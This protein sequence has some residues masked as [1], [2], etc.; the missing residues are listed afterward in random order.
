MTPRDF[1]YWLQGHFEMNDPKCF[2]TKQVAMVKA[3]LD[4]VFE[5]VTETQPVNTPQT[6][7]ATKSFLEG[8]GDKNLVPFPYLE[9]PT[10]KALFDY[11]HKK[12]VC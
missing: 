5:N 10:Q 7:P 2:T 12:Q 6:L 1:C 11:K 8:R 3:H 9:S 4:L